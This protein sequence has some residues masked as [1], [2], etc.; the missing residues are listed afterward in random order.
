ML[1]D[2]VRLALLQRNYFPN[3]RTKS[4]EMPPCFTSEALTPAVAAKLANAAPYAGPK[5]GC[6]FVPY[7]LTRFN[8]G[9]RMCGI[10]H[11][12]AYTRLVERIHTDWSRIEPLVKSDSSQIT[13]KLHKDGRIFVMDYESQFSRSRSYLEKQGAKKYVAKADI[14]HFYPSIYTH[15]I[16]WAAVGIEEAKKNTSVGGKWYNRL[17]AAVRDCKRNETNG[18]LIGPGTSSLIA[19]VILSDVDRKLENAGF[20]FLRFI[21]DYTC[22]A[23]DRVKANAFIRSLE[24]ALS[25]Y[26]LLLNFTK[27]F[28]GELTGSELP[29]WIPALQVDTLPTAPNFFSL[30]LFFSRAVEIAKQHPEGSVL[31]YAV[32]A[33]KD[34][35]LSQQSGEYVLR[36]LMALSLHHHHLVGSLTDYV[37]FGFDGQ[38]F[39][40]EK[41]LDAILAS[42]VESRRSDAICWSLYLTYKVRGNISD[43]LASQVLKTYDPCALILLYE[44]GQAKTRRSITNFVK[45]SILPRDHSAHERN[46][47]LIHYLLNEKR[48]KVPEVSDQS[49]K[50]LKAEKVNLYKF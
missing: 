39:K 12:Y 23:E 42:S 13:A 46:W 24:I 17:D 9:P 7:T 40:Y 15:A 34:R 14:S 27:T 50:I 6:D 2:E 28:V 49:L 30:K 5:R 22:F 16:S 48:L 25:R 10:P 11:P 1:A 41:E 37:H 33:L 3:H 47:I 29:S 43:N 35:Q 32:H 18:I 19:E 4:S 36:T 44:A 21:D 8:G 38:N 26:A 31:R 45:K 20:E